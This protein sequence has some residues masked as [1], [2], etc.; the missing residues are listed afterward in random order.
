VTVAELI[1]Q[2]GKLDPR[3]LVLA[4]FPATGGYINAEVHVMNAD[5]PKPWVAIVAAG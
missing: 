3:L 2:L 4:L 5:K 1:E